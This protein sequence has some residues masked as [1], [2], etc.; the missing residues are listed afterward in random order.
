MAKAD[1]L[2]VHS[3]VQPTKQA[4]CLFLYLEIVPHLGDSSKSVLKKP[5]KNG[6]LNSQ[7]DF[8]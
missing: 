4:N 1:N 5:Y 8:F 6:L 2:W 3:L 7:T